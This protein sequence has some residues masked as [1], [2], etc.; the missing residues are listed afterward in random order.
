MEKATIQRELEQVSGG[1]FITQSQIKKALGCGNDTLGDV[2][3]GLDYITFGK[4]KR[5]LIKDITD[6]LWNSRICGGE[7]Q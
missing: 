4:K 3:S 1:V 6:R 7:K 5:Y 2:V